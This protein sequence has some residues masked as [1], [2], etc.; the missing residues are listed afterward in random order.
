MLGIIPYEFGKK[1]G[2]VRI[3]KVT[4]RTRYPSFQPE[5][6][7]PHFEHHIVIVRFY[8]HRITADNVAFGV[9]GYIA[10]IGTD[11]YL[12]SARERYCESE[13]SDAVMF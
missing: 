2:A 7:W 4:Y 9:I 11:G 10:G 3:G 5:R 8:E 13:A 1:C 12:F 6:V